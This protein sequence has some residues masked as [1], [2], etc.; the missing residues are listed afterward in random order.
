MSV[1]I[2]I[3]QNRLNEFMAEHKASANEMD[4]VFGLRPGCTA[5]VL[6]GGSNA[7]LYAE[8]IVM[9]LTEDAPAITKLNALRGKVNAEGRDSALGCITTEQEKQE[10][11][12]QESAE[13]KEE[14]SAANNSSETKEADSIQEKAIRLAE[15]MKDYMK[16]SWPQ[17]EELLGFKRQEITN[18][19]YAHKNSETIGFKLSEKKALRIVRI[20]EAYN[21]SLD[22]PSDGTN[23]PEIN[24]VSES[25]DTESSTGKVSVD[26][27]GEEKEN[28][29][30]EDAQAESDV[31]TP[32]LDDMKTIL[33][34]AMESEQR[35]KR[36]ARKM[37]EDA[38]GME[39]DELLDLKPQIEMM[40]IC[41]RNNI[42]CK[43]VP[44]SVQVS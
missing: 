44:D 10:S 38:F 6:A 1:Y 5:L 27:S 7:S 13:K 41:K 31:Y 23:H 30:Q 3:A 17:F 14:Q 20:I 29:T 37:V 26:T 21:A 11:E 12:K 9:E 40:I 4:S 18:A 28:L 36:L 34:T 15:D 19:R 16:C 33:R 39:L 43:V 32:S 35:A 22:V 42:G 25:A 24:P 2:E 8:N